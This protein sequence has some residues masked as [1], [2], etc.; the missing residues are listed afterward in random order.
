MNILFANYGQSDNN[1][2]YHI[3]GFASGLAARGHDV[4]VAVAKSVPDGQ[5]ES[6]GGF[7]MASHRT[8]LKTGFT[9]ADGRSADVLHVWTPRETMR[10]F[11]SAHAAAWGH[12]SLVVHLEDNEEAIFERFTGCSLEKACTLDEPWPKGLIHP[13][14]YRGFLKSAQGVTMVHRCLEPLVPS[15]LPRQEIVPVMDF[16]FFTN[17]GESHALRRE[18]GIAPTTRVVVFNGN[19]HAAAALDIRQLY[20]AVDLLI[21]EGMDLA[22]VRTGHVL[23]ANYDGLHFRPGSRCH[24]L[25]FVE[26]GMVPEIMS[27]ADVAVQPGD[28]DYFNAHRLPAKVPEYL[29]MGKPLVMGETNI[30]RELAA[31]DAALILPGMSPRQMADAIARLLNA[32]TETA[33]M[34]VRGREFARSRF[35]RDAVIPLLERFYQKCLPAPAVTRPQVGSC[36]LRR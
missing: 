29:A 25:G 6:V 9:F 13:V 7:R 34:A 11:A 28:G 27:L 1:S 32:P 3:V 14:H 18:L 19:D 30:G 21:E 17:G 24:E 4:C 5:F 15:E 8:A 2:A 22:F 31:A 36:Q 35:S 20:E 26:R 10:L 23:P 16:R 12:A 33:A